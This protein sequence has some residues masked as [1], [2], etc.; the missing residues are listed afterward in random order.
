MNNKE[1]YEHWLNIAQYDLDTADAMFESGRYIYVAFTCQQAI[2]K[3]AKGLYV[4]NFDKEAKHTH[5]INFVLEEVEGILNS[6]KYEENKVFF[7]E[8]TSY[9]VS[10][11]Y[12]TYKQELSQ[13]LDKDNTQK[14]L[15]KTKEAFEW[16]KSQAK[17]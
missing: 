15:A 9:Y 13:L 1:K 10:G 12:E 6:E 3:L 16:L 14:L 7:S 17:F 5:N 2:E 11:R 4:Y 8:L